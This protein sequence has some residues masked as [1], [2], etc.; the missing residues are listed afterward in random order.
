MWPQSIHIPNGKSFFLSLGGSANFRWYD[1]ACPNDASE[2]ANVTGI[3]EKQANVTSEWEEKRDSAAPQSELGY[4]V[5]TLQSGEERQ[6]GVR[7]KNGATYHLKYDGPGI[8]P[9][10]SL[11][12][13]APNLLQLQHLPT[14]YMAAQLEHCSPDQAN[15]LWSTWM[16]GPED[17]HPRL[18]LR[19]RHVRELAQGY[20]DL[21]IPILLEMLDL[22]PMLFRFEPMTGQALGRENRILIVQGV[23]GCVENSIFDGKMQDFVNLYSARGCADTEKRDAHALINEFP[24]WRHGRADTSSA[25]PFFSGIQHS[26]KRNWGGNASAHG[27][28]ATFATSASGVSYNGAACNEVT[29]STAAGCDVDSFEA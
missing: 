8:C 10:T 13:F 6:N 1:P 15:C 11:L 22:Q 17:F 24:A 4:V 26:S 9:S 21:Q 5:F 7:M 3:V 16:R 14:R 23:S 19:C 29:P 27:S 28:A 25:L 20:D 2:W 12:Q 18:T